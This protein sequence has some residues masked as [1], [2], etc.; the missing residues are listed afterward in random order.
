VPN[1]KQFKE[2]IKRVVILGHSGFIGRH[3]EKIFNE[4]SPNIELIGR[5]YPDLDLCFKEDAYSLSP[6]FDMD[7]AVIMVSGIKRQLGDSL[8]IFSKNVSMANNVC[9]VLQEKPVKHLLFFSSAA[10][11][12]EE[13]DNI[14]IT[15]KTPVHPTSYY[16]IAKYASECLFRKVFSEQENNSLIILRPPLVY[17]P[18]DQTTIYG[19]SGFAIKAL[20][21]EKITLWGD[22]SEL[23]EFFYVEDLAKIVY[24]LTF[25]NFDGIVNISSGESSDFKQILDILSNILCYKLEIDSRPRTRKKVDNKFKNNRLLE[26]LPNVSF[27][28]LKEGI[29]NVVNGLN[30][31][32]EQMRK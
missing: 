8:D 27:T 2:K 32:N 12:G 3:I 16:G 17:G 26:V 30:N 29:K 6:L 4:K 5:S 7:T 20:H 13:I 31:S 15:E 10:V 11:Y 18:G 9:S 21:K 1:N 24:D 19:P 14:D 23:R 25:N 28:D 22:G